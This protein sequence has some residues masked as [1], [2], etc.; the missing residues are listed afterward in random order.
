MTFCG[1]SE[2]DCRKEYER[3]MLDILEEWVGDKSAQMYL[4]GYGEFDEF[5]YRCCKEYKK[6]HPNVSLI[7]ITPYMTEEY[8]KKRLRFE[9]EKYDEVIYPEIENK[10]L[11]FA[12]SYRNEWM[13]EKADL[14][15]C[16]IT[17]DWGGAYKTYEYAKRK[18]KPLI[19][20]VKNF[21]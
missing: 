2:F 10:P 3:E 11:R 14:V 21:L 16:G 4:G 15:I 12:I 5:A 18:N 20:V 7:F 8:Q 19:N 6:T 9:K 17:H 13:V 1:H